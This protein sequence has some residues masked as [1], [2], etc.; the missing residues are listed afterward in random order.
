MTVAKTKNDQ[1]QTGGGVS[2]AGN[3]D[4]HSVNEALIAHWTRRV[5]IFTGVMAGATVLLFVATGVS[6]YFL[7]ETDTHISGQ[8]R[9]MHAQTVT[10]RAQVRGNISPEP[11]IIDKVMENAQIAG[12]DVT[13]RW[14]NT[15]LTDALDIRMW[16][17][18][19]PVD[20]HYDDIRKFDCPNVPEPVGISPLVAQPGHV[21][22]QIAQRLPASLVLKALT[23]DA[24]IIVVGHVRYRDIF[25]DDPIHSI[26]WCNNVVPNDPASDKFSWISL[27]Q[28]AR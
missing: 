19:I 28:D 16:W 8:L 9:E 2:N 3:P 5:G 6:A 23:H 1:R 17:N 15:G 18:I 14:K 4:Q 26:D 27:K 22:L 7:W 10:T 21:F 13:P 25:P 12:W 20:G 11:F 24:A